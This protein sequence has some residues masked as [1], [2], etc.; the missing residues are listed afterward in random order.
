MRAI[1]AWW[2]DN[3]QDGVTSVL[4]AYALGKAQRIL[5]GLIA[6]GNA[7]PAPVYCHG[8]VERINAAY[9]EAGVNLPQTIAVADAPADTQW[10]EALI[11][12]PPIVQGSGWMSRFQ[13]YRTA[14][15]SGWMAIRGTRRRRNL[16]RGFVLSDHADWDA[17]NRAVDDTGASTVVVTHGY[18]DEL[19]R[20][21][22]EE[23]DPAVS[24]L[25]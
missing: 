25:I 17:L 20:W 4:F 23:R 1:A 5:M 14:F 24:P 3:R 22:Q 12:A 7:L 9:R 16:G 21:L 10:R 18:R 6:L 13:P 15:A 11:L 2:E 19:A 8:A